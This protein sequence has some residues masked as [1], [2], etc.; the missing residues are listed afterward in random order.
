[1]QSVTTKCYVVEKKGKNYGHCVKNPMSEQLGVSVLVLVASEVCVTV[2]V[3]VL[4]M[5]SL[6][7][8]ASN[9]WTSRD[10]DESNWSKWYGAKRMAWT[11]RGATILSPSGTCVTS[12]LSQ[13]ELIY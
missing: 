5:K 1:M 3:V 12:T 7:W 8:P 4:E 10:M 13:K 9:G 11:L 2:I 6:A